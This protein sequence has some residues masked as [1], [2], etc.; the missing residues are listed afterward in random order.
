MHPSCT[1]HVGSAAPLQVHA[2]GAH[3]LSSHSKAV[4]GSKLRLGVT[5]LTT[6]VWQMGVEDLELQ[7]LASKV[8]AMQAMPEVQEAARKRLSIEPVPIMCSHIRACMERHRS[9]ESQLQAIL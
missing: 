5:C 2:A 9:A 8:R 4:Q 7:L 3:H 1:E 6:S